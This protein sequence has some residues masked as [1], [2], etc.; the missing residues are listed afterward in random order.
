MTQSSDVREAAERLERD[1]K[2]SGPVLRILLTD[3]DKDCGEARVE[4]QLSN[5]GEPY[6]VT[7]LFSYNENGEGDAMFGLPNSWCE[8]RGDVRQLARAL[9]IELKTPPEAPVTS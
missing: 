1:L 8:T 9:G 6:W 2:A 7:D 3:Y 5:D 4:F